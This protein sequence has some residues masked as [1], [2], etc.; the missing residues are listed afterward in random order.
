[1]NSKLRLFLTFTLLVVTIS[2]SCLFVPHTFADDNSDD[3]AEN[4]ILQISPGLQRLS[5]KTNEIANHTVTVKNLSDGES[6]I[7]IYSTPFFYSGQNS[8]P[9]FEIKNRFT[10]LHEWITFSANDSAPQKEIP[11]TLSPKETKEI[12]Y[13]ITVPDNAPG[14]GQYAGIF[15]EVAGDESQGVKTSTR[16]GTILYA[17]IDGDIITGSSITNTKVSTFSTSGIIT[18]SADIENTGNIDFQSSVNLKASTIFGKELYN[19]TTVSTILPETTKEV[20]VSWD[21]HSIGFFKIDYQI[22]ALDTLTSSTCIVFVVP[23]SVIV[24]GF[25]LLTITVIAIIYHIK[26]RQNWHFWSRLSG[27]N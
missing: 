4:A 21:S 18:V 3:M 23:I 11:I 26:K 1:M 19:N 2:I 16:V 24:L 15:A 7:L 5:L 10:K 14:G 22:K 12:T 6:N 13:S 9:N 20:S 25:L 17:N 8:S 27:L